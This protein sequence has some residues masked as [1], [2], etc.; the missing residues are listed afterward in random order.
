MNN[1]WSKSF[2]AC[3]L[4]AAASTVSV[5][6]AAKPEDSSENIDVTQEGVSQQELAAI[7]VLSEIC[8]KLINAKDQTAFE[9]GYSRLTKDYMP[10]ES[11]PEAALK[12]LSKQKSFQSAL[13]EARGDARQAGTEQNTGVCNDVKD[14]RS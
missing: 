13:K 12:K 7:Y 8:P 6:H 1:K 10:K 5:T 3:V 2:L 4:F 9:S 11:Q 14:Y